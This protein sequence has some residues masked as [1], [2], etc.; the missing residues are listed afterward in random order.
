M[1]SPRPI[2]FIHGLGLGLV[3]YHFLLFHLFETFADRPL[4]IPLQPQVSQD[5]FHPRFLKPLDRHQMADRLTGLIEEL[6]WAT[7][8]SK[9]EKSNE[10]D[11]GSSRTGNTAG[12]GITMLSHSKYESFSHRPTILLF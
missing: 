11:V 10:K 4:L 6:G 12:R 9:D 7:S 3:Q 1:T 2:V 5:I 8:L